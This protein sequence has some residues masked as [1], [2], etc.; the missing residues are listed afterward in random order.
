MRLELTAFRLWD[1]RAAYCATEAWWKGNWKIT[2]ILFF[3]MLK[4]YSILKQI[5]IFSGHKYKV[6]KEVKKFVTQVTLTILNVDK[7]D[8]GTYECV[9]KNPLG[10][11]DGTIS[12]SGKIFVVTFKSTFVYTFQFLCLGVRAHNAQPSHNLACNNVKGFRS[13]PDWRDEFWGSRRQK[14]TSPKNWDFKKNFQWRP[15]L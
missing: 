4:T 7:R 6:H 10:E 13:F 3:S 5:W 1:W 14:K 15:V 9:A 8:F 12:L 11:S 2:S